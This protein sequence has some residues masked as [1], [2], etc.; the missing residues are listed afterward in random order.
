[1]DF[2]HIH[3]AGLDFGWQGLHAFVPFLITGLMLL[4]IG[5]K[6]NNTPVIILSVVLLIITAIK[7]KKSFKFKSK[8]QE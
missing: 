6:L 4:V 7:T 8:K 5:I 2:D 3:V 1:M